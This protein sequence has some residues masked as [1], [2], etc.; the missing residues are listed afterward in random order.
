MED[1]QTAPVSAVASLYVLPEAELLALRLHLYSPHVGTQVAKSPA[2][3]SA[4]VAFRVTT[5]GLEADATAPQLQQAAGSV[6]GQAIAHGMDYEPGG[7]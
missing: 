5:R 3:P 1:W 4:A 2:A 6:V 7:S